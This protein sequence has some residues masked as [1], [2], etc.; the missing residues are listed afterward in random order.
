MHYQIFPI[1]VKFCLIIYFKEHFG[2]IENITISWF[3]DLNN[4]LF[5]LIE[6]CIKL[7]NFRLTYLLM[8]V[9]IKNLVIQNIKI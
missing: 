6:A 9:F 3:G 7:D 2:Q 5:S 1:H 8:R 4:V